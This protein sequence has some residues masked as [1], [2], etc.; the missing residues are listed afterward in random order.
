MPINFIEFRFMKSLFLF[1]VFV[2]SFFQTKAQEVY[3]QC[4]EALEICP[5]N[6][7]SVNNIGANSTVCT[8][9][10]DDFNF[11]FTSENSIWLTFTTNSN[12]GDVQLDFT[13]LVFQT[14]VGQ[15]NQL[16]ASIIEAGVP[17]SSN[18]YTQIGNC[19]SNASANFTLNAT[20]L[21]P[22]TT[23]YVVI[24]GDDTGV[25]INSPAEASFDIL[26][27]GS[28]V[29]RPAPSLILG[30]NSSS[31][32]LNE[33]VF[34]TVSPT[35]CPNNTSYRWLINGVL[36]ATTI[37]T[38]FS[39]SQLSDGDIVT[40]ETDCYTVCPITTTA[41]SVPFS[42]YSFP[43][44]AGFDIST[45]AGVLTS[46]NGTTSAPVYSWSPSY[47][48]S[49]PN[50]LSTLVS[51]DQTVTLTLT[52]TEN[53]CTLSDNIILIIDTGIEIPNT[54]SPNG[55]GNN[56]TWR[57]KGIENYPDCV[58]KI[59]TR[60]G[61]Q[62]FQSVGYSKDKAWDGSINS[63]KAAE[64]VYFYVI[65]LGNGSDLLKGTINLIR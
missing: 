47:L 29:N 40:V 32:C 22:F 60:W 27:S 20:G 63:R 45:Q 19:I 25:G 35:D 42:V 9:C 13:N 5:N 38:V 44:D 56:E 46:I 39:T 53:G 17:C 51:A 59:Y 3:N 12:G 7:V 26:L 54:F 65:D 6:L 1:L 52:A 30:Q 48:F 28:A 49:D 23:Y 34:F 50:A 21:L 64:G 14:N 18:S 15:G 61:Q 57:I 62:V 31:I 4:S 41:N 8:G 58:I 36:V 37:D 10:E 16:Q 33:T 24:D 55:D 2:F 11:C 43:V